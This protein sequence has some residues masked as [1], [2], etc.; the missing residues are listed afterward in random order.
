MK[1]AFAVHKAQMKKKTGTLK[2]KLTPPGKV[3]KGK[4][5]T[6]KVKNSTGKRQGSSKKKNSNQKNGR[7]S[8]PSRKKMAQKS[9][10]KTTVKSG[11]NASPTGKKKLQVKSSQVTKSLKLSSKKCETGVEAKTGCNKSQGQLQNRSPLFPKSSTKVENGQLDASSAKSLSKSKAAK[12]SSKK[13]AVKRAP[14]ASPKHSSES[15][16]EG[17][18]SESI[19]SKEGNSVDLTSNSELRA[20]KQASKDKM[21]VTISPL[22][23]VQY[24]SPS[25]R[26]RKISVANSKDAKKLKIK[27][28]PSKFVKKSD[29]TVPSHGQKKQESPRI[30]NFSTPENKLSGSNGPTCDSDSGVES[31]LLFEWLISPVTPQNFFD[32]LWEKK[33]L[34][35]RRHKPQ[36]FKG[37]FSTELLNNILKK[38]DI[39]FGKHLDITSY[40]DGKRET[41]NPEGRAHAPVVWDYFNNGCSVRLLNPQ[42]YSDTVWKLLSVLQEHFGSFCGA[43]VYLTPAATQGFA[44]HY[45]DI[46]AFIL[47]LEGKKRWK[48]YS[49]RSDS[50]V[51][52]RFSSGN[53]RDADIGKPILDT[54]LEEG[55]VLYFPRGFIHQAAPPPDTHSLHLTVSTCQRNTWGDFVEKL[56]GVA[57]QT[58]I[59]E[60]V[61]FRVSLPR[62]YLTF[63]GVV[64]SDM[65]LKKM[66]SVT[67]AWPNGSSNTPLIIII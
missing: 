48:L 45:D 61:D 35:V 51:L 27:L 20:A 10:C 65:V 50:D 9:I 46:E 7:K 62:D 13:S 42:T 12:E 29:T 38:N 57:L 21:S 3:T 17:L 49:P 32:N 6:A 34:L 31:A 36:Y 2:I 23:P 24:T 55:D 19:L 60:D 44:P 37:I 14:T 43:N 40:T 52:P 28:P 33:P 25:Q 30:V 41:H 59:E 54:V 15:C 8:A 16:Q 39:Q 64:N 4:K 18:L 26:K 11:T 53:L 1:S 22:K 56:I 5:H 66:A 47:Q 67:V 63:M 58:A